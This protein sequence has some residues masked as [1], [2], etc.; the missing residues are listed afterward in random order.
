MRPYRIAAGDG[1]VL[2]K[3]GSVATRSTPQPHRL[4]HAKAYQTSSSPAT[5][6]VKNVVTVRALE[7]FVDAEIQ[8]TSAVTRIRQI[9]T[10]IAAHC[11][12]LVI[13]ICTGYVRVPCRMVAIQ[14]PAA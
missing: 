7:P 1:I 14:Y 2:E 11:F 3:T 13:V 9:A 10:A 6:P 8:I 5:A 4:R 12:G